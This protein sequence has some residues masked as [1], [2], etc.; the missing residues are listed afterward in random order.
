MALSSLAAQ[1]R[2]PSPSLNSDAQAALDAALGRSTPARLS[3]PGGVPDDDVGEERVGRSDVRQRGVRSS[4]KGRESE[5]ARK[6]KLI[7]NCMKTEKMC[8]IR[9]WM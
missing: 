6:P 8:L 2:G 3:S 4:A 9:R 7:W 5:E 1:V